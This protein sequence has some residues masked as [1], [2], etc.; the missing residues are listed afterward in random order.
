MLKYL[1]H[2][3]P[4]LL[5][6]SLYSFF[7]SHYFCLRAF[8][9]GSLQLF[10][11][12]SMTKMKSMLKSLQSPVR[13]SSICLAVSYVSTQHWVTL[14]TQCRCY[15]QDK[16]RHADPFITRLVPVSSRAVKNSWS[17][18]NTVCTPSWIRDR[19]EDLCGILHLNLSPFLSWH[20]FL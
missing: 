11:F 17:L 2:L 9:L 12:N 20:S 13:T 3:K 5:K 19:C 4:G 14:I 18:K 8:S 10:Q 15:V 7:G 16:T 1:Y 6:E